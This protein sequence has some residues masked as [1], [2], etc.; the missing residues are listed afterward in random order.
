M[1]L[2]N[3]FIKPLYNS[4]C[5]SQIPA[6]IEHLFGIDNDLGLPKDTLPHSKYQKYQHVVFFFID[7]FGWKFFEQHKNKYPF[8]QRFIKE[9][10][11]SKLTSQFP[12]TTSAHVTTMNTGLSVG[13]SGVYEWFYYE[14]KLDAVIA[15]L[16]FSFAR[17]T[18]S[19]TLAL[20]GVD[21]SEL[22]PS[23]TLYDRLNRFGVRSNVFIPAEY[24][25]SP[26]NSVVSHGAKISPY[27]TFTEGLT[28]LSEM[29]VKDNQKSYYYYYYDKIDSMGHKYGTNSRQFE[30]EIDVFFTT[31]EHVF[32]SF[33]KNKIND[34][35]IL[36]SADHGQTNIDP[37]TTIY[38]NKEI[39]N[40]AK[41]FKTNKSNIPIVPAGSCRDMFLH[42]KEE[43]LAELV[44][45]LTQKLKGKA[46]IVHTK[47][48]IKL[49]FFG[50]KISPE[51]LGRVGNLVILPFT[52]ES[53]WWYEDG[54][55]E[56]K[57]IGHHG[58]LTPDEM[59]IPFLALSL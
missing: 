19:G 5:F 53:V 4:Y 42:V 26:Y 41:Y 45:I 6:T 50:S 10:V 40:I 3:N 21:P 51:F 43:C 27:R 49:G 22:Y 13:E 34:T 25:L 54:V 7:A 11:I 47:E 23:H 55:F 15:P 44:T 14:P 31:L 52:G 59:E 58:G 32:F 39:K 12:S 29:L 46:Q 38:L 17:D 36:L 57:N 56:Q 9:G 18:T 48:L 28:N 24:A 37:K 8:L 1:D 20:T 16:L 33:I 35:L 30:S 2:S